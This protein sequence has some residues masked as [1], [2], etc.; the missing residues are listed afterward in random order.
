[1]ERGSHAPPR[2]HATPN[3]FS[4]ILRALLCLPLICVSLGF[5]TIAVIGVGKLPAIDRADLPHDCARAFETALICFV[6]AA[7][8]AAFRPSLLWLLP[9]AATTSAGAAGWALL[10]LPA[11]PWTQAIEGAVLLLPVMVLVMGS[12]WRLI[13]TGLA[14]SAAASGASPVWVFYL[15]AIRPA[16]PGI[17]RGL[18]V[19]FVLA[20]GLAPLLAPAS[21]SP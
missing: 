6:L 9:L 15:A 12:W 4:G 8:A 19:V 11:N 20:L 7:P 16:L 2:N 18:A 17:A 10:P 21:G 1:M 14:D 13:P 3:A 5:A